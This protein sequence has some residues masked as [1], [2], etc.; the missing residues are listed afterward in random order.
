[1]HIEAVSMVRFISSR[2]NA[3]PNRG[4]TSSLKLRESSSGFACKQW[5]MDDFLFQS[6]EIKKSAV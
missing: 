3:S 5:Q 6:R 4:S 2:S 1:M